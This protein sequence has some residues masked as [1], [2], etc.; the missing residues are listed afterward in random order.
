VGL[1][2]YRQADPH[3]LSAGQKRCVAIASVL[4]MNPPII[5]LDEPS[6]GLDSQK[7]GQLMQIAAHLNRQGHTVIV[8]SHDIQ[9]VSAFCTRAVVLQEGAVQYDGSMTQWHS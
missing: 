8:L 1:E 7:A 5:V 3:T 9:L 2:E 4:A 6:A